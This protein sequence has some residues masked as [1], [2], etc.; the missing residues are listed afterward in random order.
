LYRGE[1]T[2]I[3]A[4]SI[5]PERNN[6]FTA[7]GHVDSRIEGMTAF[8]DKLVYDGEK[9]TAVYT[10]NV[11]AIKDDKKGPMDLHSTD[12]TLTIEPADPTTQKKAQLKNLTA[13]GKPK[14]KVVV[15]QGARRGTGDRLIY[16]YVTDEVT[17]LADKGSEVTI[18]D[19]PNQSWS[20]ATRAHWTSHGGKVDAIN[21]Q[22]GKVVSKAAGPVKAK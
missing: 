5:T 20:N 22:G 8:A 16:D 17:L 2:Q 6:G 13:S 1:T 4:D 12:M 10:G 18:D 7:E 15:T 14:N 19:P 9:N 11:H 21:D 3:F